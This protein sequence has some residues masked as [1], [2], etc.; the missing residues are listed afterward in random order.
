MHSWSIKIH[1]SSK[2]YLKVLDYQNERGKK[3]RNCDLEHQNWWIVLCHQQ[4]SMDALFLEDFIEILISNRPY[5]IIKSEKIGEFGLLWI[6][7]FERFI[8][9][10]PDFWISE[11]GFG[12]LELVNPCHK[13]LI[14]L[15]IFFQILLKRKR[16]FKLM[17]NKGDMLQH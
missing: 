13:Q 9:W 10:F 5:M 6:H 2:K 14:V 3:S 15:N 17:Q 8:I 11:L 16:H 12:N 4:F 7:N 1:T